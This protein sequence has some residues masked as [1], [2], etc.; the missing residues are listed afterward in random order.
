MNTDEFLAIRWS[1][2]GT[3]LIEPPRFSPVIADPSFLFPEETP[4]GTWELFAHSAWGIH[5]FSSSD[6]MAWR[7]NGIVVRNAMRPFVRRIGDT[8]LLYFEQYAPF[9]LPLTALPF[10]HR[11][12]SKIAVSSSADLKRWSE[13]STL[14]KPH[15]QWMRDAILGDSVSNPCL[16]FAGQGRCGGS[17]GWRLYFSASLSW[18]DDCGFSEPRYIAVA[19]SDNATGPFEPRPKPIIDPSDDCRLADRPTEWGCSQLGAGS[20]KVLR[21]DDGW[22]GLQNKIYLDHNGSSRSAI[23][24]LRSKDGRSW[25]PA[26]GQPLLAPDQGWTQSHV[27]ACDCRFREADGTWYLYFNARDGWGIRSGRERIGRI[28]GKQ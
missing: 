11:W 3:A 22:I 16:V 5:W 12:K 19:Q 1:P 2:P 20:I 23:F 8:Y 21:L 26:Q 7:D 17:D 4:G 27:Y 9:A 6:G 28:I 18:I 15:L 13:P 25:L 10:R 24:V 14:V